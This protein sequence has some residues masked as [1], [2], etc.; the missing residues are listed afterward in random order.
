MYNMYTKI[1]VFTKSS[2]SPHV[3]CNNIIILAKFMKLVAPGKPELQGREREGREEGM[4]ER[5]GSKGGREGGREGGGG[6]E[7]SAT[8]S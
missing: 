6:R 1:N 4:G 7:F 3:K 8:L 5:E 2:N